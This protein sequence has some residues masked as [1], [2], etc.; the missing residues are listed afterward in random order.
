VKPREEKEEKEA[1][2]PMW[3]HE[4]KEEGEGLEVEEAIRTGTRRIQKY[5]KE[6]ENYH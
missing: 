6:S 4:E 3:N 2:L 1:R 5:E